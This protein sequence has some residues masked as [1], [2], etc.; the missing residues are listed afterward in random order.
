MEDLNG[1]PGVAILV[2]KIDSL[3]KMRSKI[4]YYRGSESMGPQLGPQLSMRKAT[5]RYFLFENDFE[6]IFKSILNFKSFK[7]MLFGDF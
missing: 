5:Q 2:W 4:M 1:G 7:N 3:Q 6:C